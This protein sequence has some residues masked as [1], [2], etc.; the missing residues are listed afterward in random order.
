MHPNAKIGWIAFAKG[1][2]TN[3]LE[4]W[5]LHAY[6]HK[7]IWHICICTLT[8][9]DYIFFDAC[10]HGRAI[11]VSMYIKNTRIS[12]CMPVHIYG[13]G[14]S[15]ITVMTTRHAQVCKARR[16]IYTSYSFYTSYTY[17]APTV[18][19]FTNILYI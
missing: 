6:V 3:Y 14:L 5:K 7:H 4:V 8:C 10:M 1:L 12:V 18:H 15:I 17:P 2:R 11:R 19:I 9:I 16:H 13:R